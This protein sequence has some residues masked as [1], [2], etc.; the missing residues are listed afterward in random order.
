MHGEWLR[1]PANNTAVVF[2]HGILSS[3]ETCW[4][5][6]NGAYW[7]ALLQREPGLNGLGIY[8]YSY[9]TDIFSGNYQLGDVVD[10]LKERMRLDEVLQNQWLIFVCHSMGGI[11][12]RQYL[13]TRAL[14]L[15]EANIDIGLFLVASPAL[16]S[17]YANWLSLFAKILGNSQAEALRFTQDNAWLNDLDKN[18]MNLK[19]AGKLQLSGKELIEDNFIILK[20]FFRKQ[21]VEPFSGARYF[22]E[23]YKVP[24]S[25]HFSI[26]KPENEQAIQHRLLVQFSKEMLQAEVSAKAAHP[27]HEPSSSPHSLNL[28]AQGDLSARD[29][30]GGNKTV[31]QSI[32]VGDLQH[33]SGVA[34]GE[35]ASVTIIHQ[36][37]PPTFNPLHQLPTPPADFTG[38]DAEMNELMAKL[39]TGGVTISGL[40]SMGGIGKTVLALKLAELLTP[41]YPD[42][43]FFLDLKGASDKPLSP[44]EAMAHI[45]RAYHPTAKLPESETELKPLYQ[46]VLHGQHAL[47]LMDN[48]RD[49]QQVLPLLP[50]ATCLLLVT[51]RQRFTLPGLYPK[52]LNTLPPKDACQLLLT[53]APRIGAAAEAMAKLC[54]YLPHA[55]RL[56]ASTLAEQI[57]LS[58]ADYLRRLKNAKAR[59]ELVEASLSLSYDLLNAETQMW[60]RL[61]SVFPDTF[62]Q[63][64]GAA[65]WE[66]DVEPAQK[67]L[68]VLVK[69]SLVEWQPAI[70]RYS[71]HD[72]ARLFAAK[73]CTE[74]ER[75]AGQQHHAEHYAT[76]LRS[77]DK[78]YKQGGE[79]I[80]RGLA[81][82]DLEWGN[83]QAGQ[84]WAQA[85]AEK[86]KAVAQ[87]C[88]DYPDAGTYC[89]DLRQHPRERIHWREA[90]LIAARSL[91]DRAGEGVHLSNLG[92]AYRDLGEPR[93]AVE[94]YE[95]C[96]TLHREIGDRRGEGADLGNLGVAYKNLG[97]PRRAI[98]FFE[99]ALVIDREIGDRR[100]EGADL[101]NLGNAYADLGEPRR[102]IE[103]Y[104]QQLV[105][106]REIGDRRGEGYALGNLG[107]AYENLGEPRHAIEFYEQCL[108]IA[109]EIGDRSGEGAA[110]GNLGVAYKNLDEP[111]RAIE[112][113]EQYL[114]IARE[115]GDRRGEGNALWNMS[116]TQDKLGGREQAIANAEAALK[117][118]EQI[119]DPNAAM[120]RRQLDEW[121]GQKSSEQ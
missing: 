20:K 74:S 87:L 38:R 64:A 8:V 23:P 16:G 109:R 102:A 29:V 114:V 53:I 89:L 104:E 5:H 47:L 99:Q 116:L 9:R 54:G 27:A 119:E 71:L 80:Q 117:I 78:L 3:G 59:L 37:A 58:P 7:P 36:A 18:F 81:L 43:Q 86:N 12:V 79:A 76:V 73:Q 28:S 75:A 108:K 65:V 42:A 100:G 50:P 11:V 61:L 94:F 95:K 30:V 19:A 85:N 33:T 60:W 34:I 88:S 26:A 25:D 115:I 55:L 83:I 1:K 31:D 35:K 90:A 17:E 32:S 45:I 21:V 72:L 52:D 120:V 96:L 110:L 97:E 46:S 68:S 57:D 107:V 111:R 106:T 98:E 70:R 101:G 10:D 39:E 103:F 13:V 67:N 92:V 44:A 118:Y 48:A 40:Q 2:V 113:H 41:R 82:F 22:G 69:Y 24:H 6:E 112:F 56:A 63:P 49:S 91:K 66:M 4:Q 84:A 121:R 62:D 51:S 93:R 105:I 77:A 15:I 14:D